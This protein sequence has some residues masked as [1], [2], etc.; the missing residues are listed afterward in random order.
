MEIKVFEEMV[1]QRHYFHHM[2]LPRF[3]PGPP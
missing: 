2:N 3:E 1:L